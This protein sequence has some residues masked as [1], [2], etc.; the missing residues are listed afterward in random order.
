MNM[1]CQ[2]NCINVSRISA[3]TTAKFDPR[4]ATLTVAREIRISEGER[5]IERTSKVEACTETIATGSLQE[6][7]P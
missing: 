1:A 5:E 2:L 4:S 6:S 3:L 7:S